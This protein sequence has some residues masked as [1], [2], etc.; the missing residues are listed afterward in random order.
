MVNHTMRS[1]DL[2]GDGVTD[3]A[4][5]ADWDDDGPGNERGSIWIMFL[6]VSGNVNGEVKISDVEGGFG[7]SDI[8]MTRYDRR[9]KS[10]GEPENLGEM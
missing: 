6:T 4:V 1:F 3:I 9:K 2:N 7:G 5:S 10:W 8:Y